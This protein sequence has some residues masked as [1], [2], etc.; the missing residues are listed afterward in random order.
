MEVFNINSSVI[1]PNSTHRAICWPC[2]PD[3][4]CSTLSVLNTWQIQ[5]SWW[6]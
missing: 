5:L 4:R 2:Y 1:S 6:L 3:L